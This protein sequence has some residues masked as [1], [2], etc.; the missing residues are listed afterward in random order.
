MKNDSFWELQRTLTG[1]FSKYVL[2]H[3]EIEDEIPD[4]AQIVFNLSDNP[5]FNTWSLKVAK[6]QRQAKQP[7][8][9]VKVKD[10]APVPP[11]R[12]INL[13]LVPA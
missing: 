12:L 9:I 10:L 11:S 8:V 4:G 6:S 3:P 5:G 7:M 13:K 2:A 1:E